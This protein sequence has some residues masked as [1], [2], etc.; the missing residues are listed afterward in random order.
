MISQTQT[1]TDRDTDTD[2]HRV[3]LQNL[4]L[5]LW[6]ASNGFEFFQMVFFITRRDCRLLLSQD[7]SVSIATDLS[8][9]DVLGDKSL[10]FMG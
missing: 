9:A 3:P 6:C 2:T 4:P 1:H 7:L 8:I 10:P 5:A